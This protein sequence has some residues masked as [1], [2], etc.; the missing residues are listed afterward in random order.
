MMTTGT[1][2]TK[3]GEILFIAV[4]FIFSAFLLSQLGEQAKF[5]PKGKFFAQP[6]VWPGV[7]VFGMTLFGGLHLL[8]RY[9]HRIA[10]TFGEVI[11]WLRALEFVGW[12]MVYVY[13]VPVIGYLPCTIVFTV[14]LALRMGYRKTSTLLW[15][16]FAGLIIVIVFKT[17]LQVKIPGAAAYEFL[18]DALR[19][20]MIVYF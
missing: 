18:P 13:A 8:T 2:K 9:K 7:G 5:N 3:S 17:L 16:A 6:A 12:F 20:F 10:G 15:A 14:T 1:I 19:N 11:T 4:F